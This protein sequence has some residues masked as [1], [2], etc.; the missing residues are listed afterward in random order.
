MKKPDTPLIIFF[1][2][3]G[4]FGLIILLAILG[5]QSNESIEYLDPADPL[6]INAKKEAIATLPVFYSLYPKYP[7][8]SYVRFRFVDHKN[9]ATHVWGKVVALDSISLRVT[10]IN[11]HANNRS[12]IYP[13]FLDLTHEQ[14][15]DWLIETGND[16]IRGGFTTQ[17]ILWRKIALYPQLKDSL[18]AQL[19][20]FSDRLKPDH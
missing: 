7:E 2:I 8:H 12:D 19:G 3:T 15:E 17:V 4:L 5:Q 18:L 9:T 1:I 13:K 6:L 20:L 10:D 16:S 14:I 11:L